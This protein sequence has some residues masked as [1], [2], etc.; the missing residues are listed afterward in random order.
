MRSVTALRAVARV[1]SARPNWR[2]ICGA[3]CR[4]SRSRIRARIAAASSGCEYR[5]AKT[6]SLAAYTSMP[7]QRLAGAEP[8]GPAI[9]AVSSTAV[10]GGRRPGA[11]VEQPE[12][13]AQVEVA[14]RQPPGLAAGFRR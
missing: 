6:Q 10:A 12:A 8:V 7:V 5:L 13:A 2:M 1:V 3:P 11:V 9:A 4:R 14:L